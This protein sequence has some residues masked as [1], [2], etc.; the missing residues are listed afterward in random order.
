MPWITWEKFWEDVNAAAL[1][2]LGAL[3]MGVAWIIRTVFTDKQRIDALVELRKEDL[4]RQSEM[5]QDLRV[6]TKH[7]L[8]DRE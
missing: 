3:A 4:Q 2:L 8:G 1:W 6:L 7:L 5:Q